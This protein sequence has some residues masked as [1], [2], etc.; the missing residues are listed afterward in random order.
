MFGAGSAESSAANGRHSETN[1]L[2]ATPGQVKVAEV[3]AGDI[4]EIVAVLA[5]ISSFPKGLSQEVLNFSGVSPLEQMWSPRN[6]L[7]EM[8]P[9]SCRFCRSRTITSPSAAVVSLPAGKRSHYG[10]PCSW[11]EMR[12]LLDMRKR[13]TVPFSRR[14]R[15]AFCMHS[16]HCDA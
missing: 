1:A 9:E 7:P 5:A 12:A 13:Y 6:V 14:D 16:L 10:R 4:A 2:V 3:V 15:F 8:L 11:R